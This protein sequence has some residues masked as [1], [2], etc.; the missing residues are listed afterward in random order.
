MKILFLTLKGCYF[1]EI[2]LGS[3]T[4]E[5]RDLTPFFETRLRKNGEFIKYDAIL[6][7]NGYSLQSR[8]MLVE[9]IK[10]EITDCFEINLGRIINAPYIEIAGIKTPCK[11]EIKQARSR[12]KRSILE[13]MTTYSM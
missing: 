4:T 12:R 6:F 5:Y 8:R 7:Q 11:I 2:A 1:D 9:H 13:S 3:K 10:T